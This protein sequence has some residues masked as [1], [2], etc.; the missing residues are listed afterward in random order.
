[1]TFDDLDLI[2]PLLD[3]LDEEGYSEPT[4][5]QR[6][7]IPALFEGRDILGIAQTG[8]GKTAAFSLPVIQ[9]LWESHRPGKPRVRALV[10]SPTRELA[11]QIGERFEAYGKYTEL[12][13][14]VIFGGVGQN[15]QVE[16]L[17][18]GIDVLVATPGR[19]LDLQD[20]G[21]IDLSNVEFLVLDEA[22]R[23][24]DMG[25]IRDIRKIVALLPERR[26]N[27]LFS[28]TMPD[29][30]AKLAGSLLRKPTRVEVV[31]ES[32]PVERID[33][34]VMFVPKADKR[35]L[36]S[37]LLQ[38]RPMDTTIVFTRTKH[39]A[40]RV[41]QHLERDG[42]A[43]AAIHGNKSQGARTRAL[44]GFRDGTL[45]VLVA[46]D[47]AARGIDVD[48]ITHVVNFDLPHPAEVYVHRIGRTARA[49]A[50]GIAI[51]FCDETEGPYL[52]A[53]EKLTRQRLEVD[54]EHPWHDPSVRDAEP[55]KPEPKPPRNRGGGGGRGGRGGGGGGG[56]RGGGRSRGGRR[57]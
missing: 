1:M 16:A 9:L 48:G 23:M 56:Q 12:K 54:A 13:S 4:P 43:S 57:S 17:R 7:A 15:P 25:F 28:A 35:R 2:A 33:Q 14:T 36:L 26:Q 30:I 29:E 18:A 8:T 52:K 50:D 49:G 19:L 20:Q 24:L 55:P 44:D 3:A 42:I 11:A 40:N 53:I 31:P 21:H 38:K 32:T 39:G 5:I 37:H 41:V 51:S 34:S 46:T 47:V 27:L 10:V 45:P 6:Q 22:D